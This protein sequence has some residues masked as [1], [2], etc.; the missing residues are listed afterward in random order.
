MKNHKLYLIEK[1]KLEKFSR[2]LL[3]FEN[4]SVIRGYKFGILYVKEGQTE[5]N[6]FY[7]NFQNESAFY[8]EFLGWI[9]SNVVLANHKGFRGGLDCK[10]KIKKKY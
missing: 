10:G 2:D 8:N 3:D 7:S 1:E 6:Q 5:E 9:G 4:K